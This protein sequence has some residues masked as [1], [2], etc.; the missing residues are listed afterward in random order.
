MHEQVA[1]TAD[2]SDRKRLF[3]LRRYRDESAATWAE[4]SA[5]FSKGPSTPTSA[6]HCSMLPPP[7]LPLSAAARPVA[8]PPCG[9]PLCGAPGL[10]SV[11]LC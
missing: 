8:W 5:S 10:V 1:E 4:L 9:C 3:R 11:Q 6:S 7:P 2:G